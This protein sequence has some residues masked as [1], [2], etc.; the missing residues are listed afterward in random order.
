MEGAIG[1]VER[2]QLRIELIVQRYWCCSEKEVSE[3]HVLNEIDELKEARK[4]GWLEPCSE[5]R[6]DQSRL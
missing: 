6:R 4:R 1:E 2:V 3:A 5:L